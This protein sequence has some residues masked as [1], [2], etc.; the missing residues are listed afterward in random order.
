MSK[1]PNLKDL[2]MKVDE[3]TEALKRERADA[4]NQRNR[5][6]QQIADL[7]DSVKAGVIEDLLPVIDNFERALGHVPKELEGNDYVKGVSG[8]VKQFEKTLE[9]I[10]VQKI[11][12]AGEKFDPNLHEAVSVEGDGNE[13]LVT[14]E[15]QPG[16]KIGERVIRHAR[17]KI[18]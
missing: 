9:D 16:Y 4:I 11:K 18:R 13:E 15:M 10:G 7:R 14:E 1:K 5:H 12:S 17:V 3:L 8:V 2:Q 6:E